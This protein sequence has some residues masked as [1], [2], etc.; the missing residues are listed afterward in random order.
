M[1]DLE[2]LLYG[3][4]TTICMDKEGNLVGCAL[5]RIP[6]G[7]VPVEISSDR[8]EFLNH[9]KII[10]NKL[11]NGNKLYCANGKMY[12]GY[13]EYVGPYN[14]DEKFISFSDT[15]RLGFFEM[16]DELENNLSKNKVRRLE[17][18]K[19]GDFYMNFDNKK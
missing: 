15:N 19:I 16:L 8:L 10:I 11:K 14:E 18:V 4:S 7:V 5:F 17:L 6:D 3:C 13:N 1:I 12:I 2:S 9:Y